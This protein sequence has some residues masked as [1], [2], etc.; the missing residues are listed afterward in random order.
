[1]TDNIRT[2]VVEVSGP[3]GLHGRPA[4]QLAKIASG[5]ASEITLCRSE[6]PENRADCRSILSLLIL[7]ATAGT[8]LLLNVS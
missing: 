1:M 2:A 6:D 7:A 4:A 3:M 5:F 8:K